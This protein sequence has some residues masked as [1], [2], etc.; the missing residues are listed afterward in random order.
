[1]ALVGSTGKSK[2]TKPSPASGAKPASSRPR[3]A[4]KSAPAG[5]PVRKVV[6]T[7][8]SGAISPKMVKTAK[9]A[10]SNAYL[11]KATGTTKKEV[12]GLRSALKTG[13]VTKREVIS[14]IKKGKGGVKPTPKALK[15]TRKALR[16]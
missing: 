3:A 10:T 15:R 13:K 9:R 16:G 12:Q 1:M 5:I 6:K 14:G 8:K 2:K 7:L 4:R 11:I